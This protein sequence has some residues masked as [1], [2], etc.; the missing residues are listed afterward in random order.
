MAPF[1][2][3][4]RTTRY[5][6]SIECLM[7]FESSRMRVTVP[8]SQTNHPEGSDIDGSGVG[9]VPKEGRI[10]SGIPRIG[11]LEGK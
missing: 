5:D 1:E 6:V 7:S 4:L 3:N 10:C 11:N 9:T 8:T 2:I